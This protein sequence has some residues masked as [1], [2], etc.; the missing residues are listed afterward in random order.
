MVHERTFYSILV[1]KN[2]F[3]R[4]FP[5]STLPILLNVAH[6]LD[7]TSVLKLAVP[8]FSKRGTGTGPEPVGFDSGPV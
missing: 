4:D 3:T 1:F 6:F 8:G 2:Y 7:L 5:E